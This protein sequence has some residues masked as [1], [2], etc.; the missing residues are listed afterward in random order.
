M[1]L[2]N[3]KMTEGATTPARKREI[4]R[5]L[6]DVSPPSTKRSSRMR[7]ILT[8]AAML[9]LA[10]VPGRLLAEPAEPGSR[11]ASAVPLYEGLGK[12]VRPVATANPQ[13]QK[14]FDQGLNFMYAFNHDEAVRAFRQAAE[15]D[16]ACALAQWGISLSLGKNYNYPF[17]PQEKAKAAWKALES[18]RAKGK[19]ESAANRAL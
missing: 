12:H 15:L 18:A 17:F 13:A 3:V 4:V 1:P 9:V 19:A 2:V 16:P 8:I 14:F 10:G 5:K 11:P 7:F 6:T